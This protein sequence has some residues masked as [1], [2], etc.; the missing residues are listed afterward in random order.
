MLHLLHLTE[1]QPRSVL[2]VVLQGLDRDG[3]LLEGTERQ[4]GDEEDLRDVDEDAAG[5]GGAGAE[6]FLLI[7]SSK[8]LFLRLALLLL[9]PTF[10]LVPALAGEVCSIREDLL[11]VNLPISLCHLRFHF[12][13]L[14]QQ[15]MSESN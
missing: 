2:R 14:R 3:D 5:G 10:S 8:T 9:F 13:K 4:G 11:A 12:S 15:E 6:A 7:L 1:R